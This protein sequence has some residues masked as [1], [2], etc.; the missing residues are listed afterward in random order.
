MAYKVGDKVR[1]VSKWNKNTEENDEGKMDKYLGTVMTI[2]RVYVNRDGEAF[3]DME[4]DAGDRPFGLGWNWNEHCI[5]ELVEEAKG[6][7][8]GINAGDVLTLDNGDKLVVV[9]EYDGLKTV[10]IYKT[11]DNSLCEVSELDDKLVCRDGGEKVM[12]I[13][14]DGEVLYER[15]EEEVKEMTLKEVCEKLGYEVKIIKD[16]E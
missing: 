16:G 14:R 9:E 13:T 15:P 5:E 12:K 8:F 6:I 1:I 11:N 10:D 7:K 2:R 4:E 3:Y